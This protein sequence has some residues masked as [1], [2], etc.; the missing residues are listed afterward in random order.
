MPEGAAEKQRGGKNTK[1]KSSL[2]STSLVTL[3][4]VVVVNL[5]IAILTSVRSYLTVAMI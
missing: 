5:K 2:F 3:V 4:F 1:T